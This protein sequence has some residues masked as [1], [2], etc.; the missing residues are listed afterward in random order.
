MTL[1]L[2][3]LEIVQA[4]AKGDIRVPLMDTMGMVYEGVYEDSVRI[5]LPVSDKILNE[6]G[7]AHSG[8][9]FSVMDAAG[10]LAARVT[11]PKGKSYLVSGFQASLANRLTGDEEKLVARASVVKGYEEGSNN[12]STH[13][14]LSDET[15]RIVAQAQLSNAVLNASP[16]APAQN[17]TGGFQSFFN[18]KSGI[19]FFSTLGIMDDPECQSSVLLRPSAHLNNSIGTVHGG[20]ILSAMAAAANRH[21]QASLKEGQRVDMSSISALYLRAVHNADDPIAARAS[22]I[23]P[24]S[25]VS[26]VR[27][28]LVDCGKTAATADIGYTVSTFER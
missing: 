26:S 2:S 24:G 23:K 12:V 25:T 27:A 13:V 9:L 15:G 1:E 19:S 3:G 14:Q 22:T 21:V 16:A 18:S 6:R 5:A 4:S 11:L 8:A 20:V 17:N 7:V 10:G 28:T